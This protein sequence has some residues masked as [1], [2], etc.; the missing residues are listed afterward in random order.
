[1][2]QFDWRKFDIRDSEGDRPF[3]PALCG[4]FYLAAGVHEVAGELADGIERYVKFVGLN[5]LKSYV[6]KSGNWKPMTKRILEKDLK[7]LRDFPKDH[8]GIRIE[9]DSGEGGE[10][11]GFGVYIDS[12]EDSP[13]FENRTSF[14][15]VDFPAQWLEEHDTDDFIEFVSEIAQIPHVQSANVGFTFKSTSGSERDAR[16]E[17][18]KKLPRYL[19]FGPCDRHLRDEMLGHTFTAHWLNYV[20]DDLAASLGGRDV[21]IAVLSKCEVRKLRKGLLIRGAKL[22]PIGD[23]NRKA[24]DL[25]CLPDVARLLKPTRLD[26]E[27]TFFATGNPDFD[28]AKWIERMDHSEGRPWDNSDAL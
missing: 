14:L 24:P 22:P 16:L 12:Y 11:G 26:V 21:I 28:A 13:V 10:P 17:I 2:K 6:A 20:D 15:R 19:G 4:F 18:D 23:I 3:L 27:A 5:A 8:V 1:M 9:Y 7:H 25:G